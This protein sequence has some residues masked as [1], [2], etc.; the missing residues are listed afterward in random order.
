MGATKSFIY[1]HINKNTFR[2]LI[3][4]YEL[5]SLV[6]YLP[7]AFS[8]VFARGIYIF[9]KHLDTSAFITSWKALYWNIMNIKD[10]LEMRKIVQSNR[11]V[12]D[13]Y[14]Y[15]KIMVHEPVPYVFRKYYQ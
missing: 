2:T 9:I 1:F 15:K 4:N 3:K 6:K 8:I 5:P 14:L 7:W 10:T 11:Q 12:S 13:E